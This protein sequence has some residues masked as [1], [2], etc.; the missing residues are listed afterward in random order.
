[1]KQR[2]NGFFSYKSRQEK[3]FTCINQEKKLHSYQQ[4][5]SKVKVDRLQNHLLAVFPKWPSTWQTVFTMC[6][7]SKL[8][9]STCWQERTTPQK[10]STVVYI[11]LKWRNSPP[12]RA[13]FYSLPSNRTFCIIF[14]RPSRL[15]TPSSITNDG[16]N[17]NQ[18]TVLHLFGM[19][20][21]S[22]S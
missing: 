18:L 6:Y 15:G 16:L 3:P 5:K 7:C 19:K 1:M 2:Q 13:L 21:K 17:K 10:P 12:L 9:M 20:S 14:P 11:G 8:K 22:K 4:K